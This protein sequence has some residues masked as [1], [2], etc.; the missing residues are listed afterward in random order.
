MTLSINAAFDSGN[1][2]VT[3]IDGDTANLEIR[4][5]KDSVVPFSGIG[6]EGAGD[7]APYHQRRKK[8]LS[9]RLAG[10]QGKIQR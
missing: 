9:R 6:R 4:T 8:R 3:S 2:L 7:H 1:I 10:L 5:D